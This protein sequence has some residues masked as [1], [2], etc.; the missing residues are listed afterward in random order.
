MSKRSIVLTLLIGLLLLAALSTLVSGQQP[1]RE[2]GRILVER[3]C[4]GCHAVSRSGQSP[5][6]MAPPFRD[7]PKKYPVEH[8]AESLAEGI[9]VGHKEMPEFLFEPD[10]IEAILTY[11]SSLAQ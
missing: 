3:E 5:H 11:I 2:R 8:L 7:L 9:V 6:R 1:P 10:D 4:A